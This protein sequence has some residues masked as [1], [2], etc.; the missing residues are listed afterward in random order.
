MDFW[1]SGYLDIWISGYLDIW[2]FVIW[3]FGLWSKQC[4]YVSPIRTSVWF[5]AAVFFGCSR[6]TRPWC[7]CNLKLCFLHSTKTVFNETRLDRRG[8]KS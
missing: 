1:I 2:I 7:L 4:V 6:K 8:L 5:S 3:T